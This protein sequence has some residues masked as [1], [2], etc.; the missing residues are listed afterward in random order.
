MGRGSGDYLWPMPLWEEYENEV[1]GR[2]ADINN[3]GKYGRIGGLVTSAAFLYQF[4][5]D[6]SWVHLDIAPRMTA[7]EEDFCPKAP[8]E[9]QWDF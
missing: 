2:Y 8:W 5:K 1:K 7:T 3:I 9:H 4:A 6:Y